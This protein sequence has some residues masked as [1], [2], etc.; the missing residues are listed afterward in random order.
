MWEVQG[1]RLGC[2]DGLG[3]GL[4]EMG[5]WRERELE[6]CGFEDLE[7]KWCRAVDCWEK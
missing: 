3:C 6:I 1:L 4:A 2:L 5:C 7:Y